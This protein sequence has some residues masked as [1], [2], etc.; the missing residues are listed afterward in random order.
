[1][2]ILNTR[3]IS[4]KKCEMEMLYWIWDQPFQGSMNSIFCKSWIWDQYLQENMKWNFGNFQLK[5]LTQLKVILNPHHQ[6][7]SDAQPCT[8]PPLGGNPV[9]PSTPRRVWSTCQLFWNLLRVFLFF[10]GHTIFWD[11]VCRNCCVSSRAHFLRFLKLFFAQWYKKA[12]K[13]G[14]RASKQQEI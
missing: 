4:I 5:E 7:H 13:W 3:S 1:M 11:G 6:D 9:P 14:P 2:Q 8:S 12:S 10:D